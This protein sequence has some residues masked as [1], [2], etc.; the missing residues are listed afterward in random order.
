MKHPLAVC[1]IGPAR[2]G[3][4]QAS[5]SVRPSTGTTDAVRRGYSYCAVIQT[6]WEMGRSTDTDGAVE[7]T[8]TER[9]ASPPEWVVESAAP[10]AVAE[11]GDA[12]G[13][14]VAGMAWTALVVLDRADAMETVAAAETTTA[15]VD[16]ARAAC[17][18]D[19][20][21]AVETAGAGLAALPVADDLRRAGSRQDGDAVA[22]VLA[23]LTTGPDR[24]RVT[25]MLAGLPTDALDGSP[26]DD[27]PAIVATRALDD[28]AADADDVATVDPASD[29]GPSVRALERLRETFHVP[30]DEAALAWFCRLRRLVDAVA[31]A[32]RSTFLPP[33]VGT[34][35]RAEADVSAALGHLDARLERAVEPPGVRSAG[36]A[37]VTPLTFASDP[38]DDVTTYWRTGFSLSAV[39]AGYAYRHEGDVTTLTEALVEGENRLVVGPAGSGKSTICKTVAVDWYDADRG[40]VLYAEQSLG[41]S[42]AHVDALVA[43]VRALDGHVLVVVE[44]ADRGDADAVERIAR[45]FGDAEDVSLLF[46]ANERALAEV[47]DGA[48][49]EGTGRTLGEAVRSVCGE[50]ETP[51]LDEAT[52]TAVV[53]HFERTTGNTVDIAPDALLDQVR[54]SD[55]EGGA[56]V[57]LAY[58]LVSAGGEAADQLERDT[59]RAFDTVESFEDPVVSR[60]ALAVNA[61]AAAGIPVYREFLHAQSAD[62]DRVRAA[63]DRLD[64]L[65]LF[66]VDERPVRTNHEAWAALYLRQL[67][68]EVDEATAH[69][70]FARCVNAVFDL[71]DADARRQVE[72][73][74]DADGDGHAYRQ[75]LTPPASVVESVLQLGV[76][77][78]VLAPLFGTSADSEIEIPEVCSASTRANVAAARGD[79]YLAAGDAETARGEYEHAHAVVADSEA[80]PAQLGTKSRARYHVN[81]GKVEQRAG[82]LYAAADHY[83]RALELSRELRDRRGIGN[84]LGKLGTLHLRTGEYEDARECFQESLEIWR[85]L[86]AHHE[87]ATVLD[88]LGVAAWEQG[89]LDEAASYLDRS[90]RLCRQL[91]DRDGAADCL[92]KLGMVRWSRGS[93]DSAREAY[94]R[95]LAIREETGDRRGQ[96]SCINNL[97]NVALDRGDYDVA[98]E[99][100]ERALELF[101]EAG[102][103]RGRRLMRLS[104]GNVAMDRED[105]EEARE[106]FGEALPEFRAIGD[107]EHVAACLNNLGLAELELGNLDRAEEC[108]TEALERNRDRGSMPQV[109][110]VTN[111]LGRLARK[112]GD[113]D[114][115]EDHQRHALELYRDIDNDHGVGESLS[116]LARIERERGAEEAAFQYADRALDALLG[117]GVADAVAVLE[118]FAPLAADRGDRERALA[119]CERAQ[120]V[121]EDDHAERAA[122]IAADIGA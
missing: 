77:W 54:R 109:A 26:P 36:V 72:A 38:A 119:W 17:D 3:E 79:M 101:D 51:S 115:A 76:R 24:D 122:E 69:R 13:W 5:L 111:N 61:L 95:S 114:A 52:C 9:V 84:A 56:F 71:C 42:A 4:S 59:A 14:T 88:D 102:D 55:A 80:L 78:P 40:P 21:V 29:V 33:G 75:A 49:E 63:I 113:L 10:D 48:G 58:R 50:H 34:D 120:R 66:G 8:L 73:R 32:D 31:T 100:F 18:G 68:Q 7:S 87:T 28:R 47:A 60:V 83:E 57:R 107:E 11:L 104:L 106:Y 112:R 117:C 93:L 98:Q 25:A 105:Y 86:G 91:G 121:L 82:E 53:E 64:G 37:R 81:L 15:G 94:E 35:G 103:E 116:N 27:H 97:G 45:S 6:I 65:V 118:E 39:R 1:P 110:N 85:E 30:T 23:R 44:D 108:L 99:H 89:D 70:Q 67:V 19:R 46:E 20:A 41:G 74:V 22:A 92:N 90:L 62:A 12:C 2:S 96:A 16:R 43:F